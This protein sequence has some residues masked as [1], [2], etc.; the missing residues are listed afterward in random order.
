MHRNVYN[1]CLIILEQPL[2]ENEHQGLEKALLATALSHNIASTV[3]SKFS[4]VRLK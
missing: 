1:I 3:S 4:A 2:A